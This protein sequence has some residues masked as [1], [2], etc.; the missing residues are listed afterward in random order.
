MKNFLV[1]N[2]WVEKVSLNDILEVLEKI[3]ITESQAKYI[4]L[5]LEEKGHVL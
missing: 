1:K 5:I 3:D 2:I 4:R